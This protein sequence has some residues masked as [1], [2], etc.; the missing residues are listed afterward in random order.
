GNILKSTLSRLGVATIVS[1]TILST[2]APLQSYAA[3]SEGTVNTPILNVRSDSSTSSSIVG[4]LTEG[5]T[6]DVYAVNDEW[7][8]IDFEGQKRYVSSTYLTIGSSMSTASTSSA[9]L[10]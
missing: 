10:Y 3:T 9:S 5:T 2:L 4:K 8:Q 7:A 1:G 6:V